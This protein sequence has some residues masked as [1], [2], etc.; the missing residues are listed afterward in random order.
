M[1]LAGV[2][3][4]CMYEYIVRYSTYMHLKMYTEL[5]LICVKTGLGGLPTLGGLKRK[6]DYIEFCLQ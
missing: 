6:N 4:T 3:F 1:L 5:A 2:A